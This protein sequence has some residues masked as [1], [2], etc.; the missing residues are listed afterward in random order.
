MEQILS[1]F[2]GWFE[3]ILDMQIFYDA[4]LE[5]PV[6]PYTGKNLAAGPEEDNVQLFYRQALFSAGAI[7]QGYA[8]IRA[9]PGSSVRHEGIAARL[10]SNFLAMGDIATREL[11]TETLELVPPGYIA[12]TVDV[13]FRFE[14]AAMSP[15]QEYYEGGLFS[16]RHS[17]HVT[18]ARPWY[19]FAVSAS[20]PFAVQRVHDIPQ[21]SVSARRGTEEQGGVEPS[22]PPPPGPLSMEAQLALYGQ[23]ECA[24]DLLGAGSLA[25][26]LDKGW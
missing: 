2:P 22:P 16:I 25:L 23:Q 14:C 24:V 26:I 15:L 19:T 10:E 13:P 1:L 5:V 18:V 3:D 7:V 17:V 9:P 12:G 21:P 11:V 20:A 6:T 4:D 8:R